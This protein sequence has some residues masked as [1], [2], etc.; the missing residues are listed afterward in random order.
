MV[1][2]ILEET[3]TYSLNKSLNITISGLLVLS[4]ASIEGNKFCMENILYIS[5]FQFNLIAKTLKSLRT[6]L[7]FSQ[8]LYM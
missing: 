4:P 6:I 3:L 8:E 1:R 2:S 5:H 7:V